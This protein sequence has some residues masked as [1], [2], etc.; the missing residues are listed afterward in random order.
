MFETL[1]RDALR[2][3]LRAFGLAFILYILQ[4]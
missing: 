2:L 1:G 4:Q 3:N